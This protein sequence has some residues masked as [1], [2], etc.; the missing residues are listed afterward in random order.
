[1][2]KEIGDQTIAVT[3][4]A[5]VASPVKARAKSK[6]SPRLIVPLVRDAA[7]TDDHPRA[8]TQPLNV[9]GSI[10]E[11]YRRRVDLQ[12]AEM[13]LTLQIKAICR[14]LLMADGKSFE[15]ATKESAALYNA[16]ST[17]GKHALSSIGLLHAAPLLESREPLERNKK[18]LD[19]QLSGLAKELPIWE[20]S[21]G[22]RGLAATSLCSLIGEIG[23]LGQYATVAKVWKR[24]GVAV[25]D[26]AR[27]GGLG[28]GA[29]ADEWTRH[30]YVKRRRSVLW[31][32]GACLLRSQKASNGEFYRVYADRRDYEKAVHPELTKL[33]IHRRAQRYMEKRFLRELWKAWR[34]TKVFL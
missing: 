17:S 16:L 7:R 25:F 10:T 1:M 9:V 8:A 3:H 32:V 15:E 13:K 4:I 6:R 21:K 34:A 18:L 12:R 33:Q 5:V 19:K 29:A 24:M 27:Q 30:G 22:V 20:W 28:K 11:L 14:R 23:D 2:L 31:N 26:G